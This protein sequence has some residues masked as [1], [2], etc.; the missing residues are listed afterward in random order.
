[1]KAQL[2]LANYHTT[3]DFSVFYCDIDAFALSPCG[4]ILISV[5]NAWPVTLL[6]YA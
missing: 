2:S 3:C 5:K 6:N 1:M 4:L